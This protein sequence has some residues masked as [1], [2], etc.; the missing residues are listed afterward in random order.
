MFYLLINDNMPASPTLWI[1]PEARGRA[2]LAKGPMGVQ[3][4]NGDVLQVTVR[5]L[6]KFIMLKRAAAKGEDFLQRRG[7]AVME[8]LRINPNDRDAQRSGVMAMGV[9]LWTAMPVAGNG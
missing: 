7:F 9:P 5:S 2:I 1:V 3:L 6:G 4:P 8:W